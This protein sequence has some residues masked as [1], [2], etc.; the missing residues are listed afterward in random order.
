MF[1][2]FAAA[3]PRAPERSAACSPAF[4]G[5]PVPCRNRGLATPTGALPAGVL[6]EIKAMYD[7]LLGGI[8]GYLEGAL[9]LTGVHQT[10]NEPFASLRA[11][12]VDEPPIR[13]T[14]NGLYQA[15]LRRPMSDADW[16]NVR[17]AYLEGWTIQKLEAAIA[18]SPE[19]VP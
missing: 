15:Y 19:C 12:L 5:S 3:P 14:A 8:G 7:D 13:A 17:K 1:N 9:Y 2:R 6:P 11:W 18:V 16:A 10:K 4:Q